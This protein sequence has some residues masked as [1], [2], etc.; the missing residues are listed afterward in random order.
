VHVCRNYYRCSSEGCGVKKR[1]ERDR[2][3][4]CYVIT[5]YEGVHNHPSPSTICCSFGAHH[6]AAASGWGSFVRGQMQMPVMAP[7]I[8]WG[9]VQSANS[10]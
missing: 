4:P 1:V 9:F 5:T 7:S 10:S 8:P 6:H 2:E 3:D